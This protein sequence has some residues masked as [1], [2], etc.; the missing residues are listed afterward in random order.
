MDHYDVLEIPTKF[1]HAEAITAVKVCGG[2]VYIGLTGYDVALVELDPA[3]ES[4]RDTGFRFPHKGNDIMN[5]IHNALVITK[6]KCYM[7]HGS[8][9]NMDK[10]QFPP[11]FDGGHIYSFDPATGATEDIGLVTAR[12]T[13]HAMAGNGD[14]LFGYGIPDNHLFSCDLT[15]GEIIDFGN[16]NGHDYPNHNF[17]CAGQKAFGAYK[18]ELQYLDDRV[19]L[20][21]SYLMVYDHGTRQIEMTDHLLA[22]DFAV[23][24]SDAGIDSC[25]AASN[26]LVYIG[27]TNGVLT[28]LDPQTYRVRELGRPRLNDGP[29]CTGLAE[30]KG[31]IFGTSGW[32]VMGLFS[33]DMS[34]G[35]FIDYGHVTDAY[36]RMC[37][38]HGIDILPDGRIY[39]GETDGSRPYV[40]RLAPK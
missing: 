16:L 3:D 15:T 10:W 12:S 30:H 9:I 28:E 39:V 27:R 11:S 18:R 4:V 2:K 35:E 22:D 1:D 38:F 33:Y 17:V 13:I 21:G 26:G 23:G 8:N 7:G 34:S 20:G 19:I 36:P 29:R 6:G 5:K 25:I 37:Y 40:Y 31:R 24:K 32:P 14:F